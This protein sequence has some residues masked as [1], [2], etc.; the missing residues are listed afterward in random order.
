MGY[1]AEKRQPAAAA[2]SA[3]ASLPIMSRRVLPSPGA[4]RH[5]GSSR[6]SLAYFVTRFED[7]DVL[8]RQFGAA[9]EALL[10]SIL[11]FIQRQAEDVCRH[12][13]RHRVAHDRAAKFLGD[14]R[15][16]H[17]KQRGRAV[18]GQLGFKPGVGHDVAAGPSS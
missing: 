7:L 8:L 18:F 5:S 13:Q 3:T 10:E 6:F 2:P 1:A 12:A 9:G 4:R 17:G 11:E 16:R 15:Q 14:F